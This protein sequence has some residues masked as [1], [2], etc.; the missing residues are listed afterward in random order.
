MKMI[1]LNNGKQIPALGLGTWNSLEG[2]VY[3]AVREAIKTGYRHIDCAHIYGNEAEI[4]SAIADAIRDNDIKREELFVTSKLW[5]NS[6]A[7]ADVIPALK[8]TLRDLQLDYLDL[9]LIHWPVAVKKEVGLGDTADDFISLADL[10]IANTWVEMEKAV[11]ESLV[12]SIGVSNFS[13]KKLTEL[14]KT[15][16][17]QPAMNQIENHPFLQQHE[18]INYCQQN[19]IAITAYSPLGSQ[20][21]AVV[22]KTANELVLLDNPVIATIAKKHQAKPA[23]ILISWAVNRNVVV[24]PKSATPSRIKENFAALDIQLDTNDMEQIASL[25][26]H[27]RFVDAAFFAKPGGAYTVENIWD[28]VVA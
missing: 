18:L 14:S 13:I 17:I 26:K 25:D 10:P 27:Y 3:K 5:N 15:A 6:H 1:N 12:N 21:L 2:E 8:Q 20:V 16:K 28:E 11:S 24:I 9:Y 23:Q 19:N 7:P 22:D 4:G